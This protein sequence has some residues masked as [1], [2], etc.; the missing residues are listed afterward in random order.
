VQEP[1]GDPAPPEPTITAAT[2]TTPAEIDPAP[3]P[4]A[5]ASKKK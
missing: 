3:G 4:A 1:A 2:D 5:K